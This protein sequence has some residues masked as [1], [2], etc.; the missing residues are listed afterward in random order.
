MLQINLSRQSM[1]KAGELRHIILS[2]DIYIYYCNLLYI[3]IHIRRSQNSC[4]RQKG[5]LDC[6]LSLPR[7]SSSLDLANKPC[8]ITKD[9]MTF[10]VRISHQ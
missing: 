1:K 8:G 5:K 9:T 6:T 7:K 2:F 3:Y 4:M 10:D